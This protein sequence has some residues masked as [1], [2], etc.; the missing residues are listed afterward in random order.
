[1]T[2]E[3]LPDVTVT[4]TVPCKNIRHELAKIFVER[5]SHQ[6]LSVK[7]RNALALEFVLGAA[8]AAALISGKMSPE[9]QALS[10]LSVFVAMNGYEELVKTAND[11]RR[12][13]NG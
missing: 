4:L 5:I 1:M 13:H 7:Q 8:C 12:V 11:V 6:V 10:I 9:Y 3:S 2:A